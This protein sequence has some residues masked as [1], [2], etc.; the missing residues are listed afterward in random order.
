MVASE[1]QSINFQVD[2]VIKIKGM[3][4][5]VVLFDAFTSKV[6]LKMIS[7]DEAKY[8]KSAQDK[9]ESN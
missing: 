4:F 6:A 8:L 1:A 7:P 3:F 9:K 5:K 2:E